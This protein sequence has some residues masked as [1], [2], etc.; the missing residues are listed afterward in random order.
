MRTEVPLYLNLF[1]RQ[2][3][4][5]DRNVIFFWGPFREPKQRR[6]GHQDESR[7]CISALA[8][9]AMAGDPGLCILSF[10]HVPLG[11]FLTLPSFPQSTPSSVSRL[12]K[13]HLSFPSCSCVSICQWEASTYILCSAPEIPMSFLAH[14]KNIPLWH[15]LEPVSLP[16]VP[17]HQHQ[18]SNR[19][20][21]LL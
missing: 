17:S 2:I 5:R 18:V 10:G 20:P 4:W 9:A 13:G 14:P 16:W 15:V 1:H 3:Q 19:C 7:K 12:Y 8:G 21:A 6:P 11:P